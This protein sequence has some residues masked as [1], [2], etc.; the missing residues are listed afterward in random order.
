MEY[1][2]LLIDLAYVQCFCALNAIETQ[3]CVLKL[4]HISLICILFNAH[5]Y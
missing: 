2:F 1:R 4:S 5:E 3:I